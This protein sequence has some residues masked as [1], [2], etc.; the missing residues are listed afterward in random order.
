MTGTTQACLF[1]DNYSPLTAAGLSVYGLSSDSPKSNTT[2]ATKQS[3]PYTLLCDPSRTLISAIGMKKSPPGTTRGVVVI[4]K[5]GKL[6]AWEQ[7]GPQRTVDVVM[8]A[9]PKGDQAPVEATKDKA[10]VPATSEQSNG[11]SAKEAE[12]AAEVADTAEKLDSNTEIGPK[13]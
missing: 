10:A 1:R 8:A 3:L 12:V 11:A 6:T 9:L 13:A 7:A 2:F 4:D 5:T